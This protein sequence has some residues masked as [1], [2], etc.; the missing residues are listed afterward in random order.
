VVRSDEE[1]ETS[2]GSVDEWAALDL[3][4]VEQ[5]G[6]VFRLGEVAQLDDR[7]VVSV[8]NVSR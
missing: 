8:G 2:K 6:H 4:R 3:I 5:A 1:F 7:E